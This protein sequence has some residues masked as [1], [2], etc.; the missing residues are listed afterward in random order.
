M[1]GVSFPT[2]DTERAK[3]ASC[4]GSNVHQVPVSFSALRPIYRI[5]TDTNTTRLCDVDSFDEHDRRLGRDKAQS[6]LTRPAID[7][8]G[9]VQYR[10]KGRHLGIFRY[11]E[12]AEEY[13]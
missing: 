4:S 12:H 10:E 5:P 8:A 1:F 11:S 7:G 9:H 13:G 2:V 3:A 6:H